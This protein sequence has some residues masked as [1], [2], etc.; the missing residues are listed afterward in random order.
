MEVKDVIK[1]IISSIKNIYDAREAKN[2]AY[3]LVGHILNI[4]KK[5][6]FLLKYNLTK[7]LKN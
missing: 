1:K 6:S 5:K 7:T 2:I 4:S 3:L